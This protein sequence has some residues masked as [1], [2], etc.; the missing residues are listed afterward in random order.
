MT[1]KADTTTATAYCEIADEQQDDPCEW[2]GVLDDEEKA[3]G[4][5]D[6][7]ARRESCS[8]CRARYRSSRPKKNREIWR[9]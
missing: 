1:R 2:C 6:L 9:S 8:T 5:V 7:P 3:P 4:F